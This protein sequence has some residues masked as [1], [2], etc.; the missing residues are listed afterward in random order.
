MP[1]AI[2]P[3]A[4]LK[5]GET[6]YLAGAKADGIV[7]PVKSVKVTGNEEVTSTSNTA[8][9]SLYLRLN[10]VDR[11]FVFHPVTLHCFDVLFADYMIL[12][13]F[14]E[15]KTLITIVNS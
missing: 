9:L 13:S 6:T 15:R 5:I 8:M 10:P 3:F 11:V 1:T 14:P 2:N 4:L 12:Y 7:I